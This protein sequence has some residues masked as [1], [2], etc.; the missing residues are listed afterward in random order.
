MAQSVEELGLELLS[1]YLMLPFSSRANSVV[2]VPGLLVLM[3]LGDD[4][5]INFCRSCFLDH[6]SY[7][8]FGK[9]FDG[10]MFGRVGESLNMSSSNR[11]S[12]LLFTQKK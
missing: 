4:S 11:A 12:L 8:D 1:F 9:V 2:S 3:T 7:E 5:K 10:K 6:W